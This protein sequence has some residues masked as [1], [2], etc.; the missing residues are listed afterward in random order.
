MPGE[1]LGEM[2]G[3]MPGDVLAGMVTIPGGDFRIGGDDPDAFPSDGEG[4]V[5]TVGLDSFEV[6]TRCVTVEQFGAFVGATGYVTES[7]L[8]GWSFVFAGLLPPEARRGVRQ[9][10]VPGAPWWLPVDGATWRTPE[11]PGSDVDGRL[12]HPVTHVSW[13][14]ASAYAAWVGKRLPTEA[15]WEVAA[16]GGLEKARFAWGDELE[17][18]GQHRCNIWQGEFPTY[19]TGADGYLS[20][21]PVD[22]FPPNGYGLYN[23]AGNVWEWCSDWFSPDWHAH[24]SQQTRLRPG[25]PATGTAKVIKGGSY[26]CHVSYCNRYRVSARTSNTPDSSTGHTGFR[27]ATDAATTS[28]AS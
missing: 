23:T 9:G 8:F 18:S 25:G 22:A 27:C 11:G 14:D 10:R 3:E 24:E 21:A 17:P 15:E 26:L 1:L 20:T 12:D 4:P 6:D 13:N 28:G 7:E 2:P 19:N 16:R 5:R